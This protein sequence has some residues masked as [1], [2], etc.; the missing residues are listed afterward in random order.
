MTMTQKQMKEALREASTMSMLDELTEKIELSEDEKE[1]FN[2]FSEQ[3]Q[4][5]AMQ[6]LM[7]AAYRAGMDRS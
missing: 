5:E 6:I 1:I 3:G 4:K 2:A 7:L